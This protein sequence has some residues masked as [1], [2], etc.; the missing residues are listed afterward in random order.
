M[1]AIECI[2]AEEWD[3]PQGCERQHVAREWLRR[4]ELPQVEDLLTRELA[5]SQ[6]SMAGM[7]LE[8]LDLCLRRSSRYLIA[9][10]AGTHWHV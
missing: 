7:G 10:R 2:I 5:I 4:V 6:E 3:K 9:S 8:V 1:D